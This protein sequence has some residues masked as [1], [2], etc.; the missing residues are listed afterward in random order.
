MRI[1]FMHT[2]MATV[3]V[4]ERRLFWQAFDFR[5]H[6]AHPGLKHMR[7]VLWELPHWMHWLG[8]VL[9]AKG[10]DDLDVVDFYSQ[11]GVVTTAGNIEPQ[12][13][14]M[15]IDAHQADVYLFSPMTPNLHLAY[16]LADAVKR[17]VPQAQTIFGGVV[18]TPL[19]EEVGSHPSVD[20]V[21][22]LGM[23]VVSVI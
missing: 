8:G 10:Y 17:R 18:A 11:P 9:D 15:M 7:K 2:P 12:L 21:G 22:S 23:D 3:P 6:Q 5:Y 20:F 16:Q 14:D 4:A 19:N 13:A 1:A